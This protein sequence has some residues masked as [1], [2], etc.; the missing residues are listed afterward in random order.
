ML[1]K[2]ANAPSFFQNFNNNILEN[3]ILD[4]FITAYVNDILVFSKNFSRA[5]KACQDSCGPP[6]SYWLAAGY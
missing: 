2:L 4:L 3:D 1:F 5:Q 6:L